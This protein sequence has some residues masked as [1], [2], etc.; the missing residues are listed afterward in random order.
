MSNQAY[1]FLRW[2]SDDGNPISGK[3]EEAIAAADQ[4]LLLQSALPEA[5]LARG[6][7]MATRRIRRWRSE[8][9]KTALD[10]LEVAILGGLTSK[11]T[12]HRAALAAATVMTA[13]NRADDDPLASRIR[14]YIRLAIENGLPREQADNEP[15]IAKWTRQL[16]GAISVNSRPVAPV[17]GLIDPLSKEALGTQSH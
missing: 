9:R 11:E 5:L 4:A 16:T 13:E 12:Y 3:F 17:D 10:D 2:C 7:A 15:H 14:E 8:P 6:S 1:S